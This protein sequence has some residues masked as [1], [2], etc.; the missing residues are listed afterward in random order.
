[1]AGGLFLLFGLVSA[2][3]SLRDMGPDRG[4]DRILM[5]VHEAARAGFWLS[6]GTLFL[7]YALVREPQGLRWFVMVPIVLA[8]LRLAAATL[9]ARR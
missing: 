3:R 6:L 4:A 9:L 1:V 7:G 2:W 8:G 5:A